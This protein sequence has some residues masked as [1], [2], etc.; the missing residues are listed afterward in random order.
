MAENTQVMRT[1]QRLRTEEGQMFSLRREGK[2]EVAGKGEQPY[3]AYE[4]TVYGETYVKDSD[5]NAQPVLS[6]GP[7]VF[8]IETKAGY[9]LK[10]AP[11]VNFITPP[12]A[13]VNV[14]NNGQVCI[15][16]WNPRE[17][18]ASET[19]RTIRVLFLDPATYNFSSPASER[20]KRFC[21]GYTGGV[22]ADFPLPC[23]TFND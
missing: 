2:I 4:I 7:H 20:C 8:T 6:A 21:A 3:R 15:G 22:P 11:I 13:H 10:D 16:Q 18:L 1:I 5:E 14:F 17:T 12:P 23:P 19:L 9:P